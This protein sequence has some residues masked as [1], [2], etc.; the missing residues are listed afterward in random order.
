MLWIRSSSTTGRTSW[1]VLLCAVVLVL[2]SCERLQQRVIERGA[3]KAAQGDRQDWLSDGALHVVLCGTGSPLPDPERAGSCAAV[4]AGEQLFL[5]DVGP[6]SWENVQL[7]RL[8]RQQLA[9]VF[10][11]HFH[12]DHIGELGEV[13]LQSW[14]AGRQGPLPIYGPPGVDQVVSGF[15]QAY[16]LDTGYRIAHHGRE[17][18][19]PSGAEMRAQPIEVGE[20]GSALV[21]DRGGLR[22][23]AIRVDHRPV[24]PAYAYLFEYAGRTAVVSGDTTRSANLIRHARDVDLLVHDVLATHVIE[25]LTGALAEH[26]AKR[27]AKLTSDIIEYHASPAEAVAVAREAE[28]RMVVFTHMVPPV[29]A[30]LAS[31]VFLHGV[32]ETDSPQVVLGRDG[33]HFTLPA[34]SQEILRED[35]D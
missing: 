32:E 30:I 25:S 35:L 26:E 7:W 23:T 5:V 8:P 19:P 21:L 4:I 14:V 31:R 34:G 24:E 28:A 11:T 3:E 2:A 20:D 17:A 27:L 1:L 9:G 33:M 16:A 13:V 12:S 29:P 15:Q 18:M 6:G 10:L 22:I